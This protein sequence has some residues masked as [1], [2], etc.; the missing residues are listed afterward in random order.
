[1]GKKEG[2]ESRGRGSAKAGSDTCQIIDFEHVFDRYTHTHTHV[3]SYVLPLCVCVLA[4]N[5]CVHLEATAEAACY[6]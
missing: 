4:G 5:Q 6:R 2:R 1:M 3:G